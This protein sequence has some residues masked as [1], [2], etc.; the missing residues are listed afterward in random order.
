[1]D[2]LYIPVELG[3]FPAHQFARL[4]AG[5]PRTDARPYYTA[6]WGMQAMDIAR[7]AIKGEPQQLHDDGSARNTIRQRF[8][9]GM[10][11][12]ADQKWEDAEKIKDAV[13]VQRIMGKD[14]VVRRYNPF[15]TDI[16]WQQD[17]I[18]FIETSAIGETFVR[19]GMSFTPTDQAW[20]DGI[21]Q[22]EAVMNEFQFNYNDSDL[23]IIHHDPRV[24]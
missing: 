9:Q 11:F 6:S 18:R 22:Q 21:S 23:T 12:A 4:L 10:A 7:K 20:L 13:K 3:S 17:I 5:K 16:S 2:K 1:M 24:T 14:Y 19:S 15:P 8:Y